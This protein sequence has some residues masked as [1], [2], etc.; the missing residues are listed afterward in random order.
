MSK[1][2]NEILD[3]LASY[4]DKVVT[5]FRKAHCHVMVRNINCNFDA[6]IDSIERCHELL[7]KY[8]DFFELVCI[9]NGIDD[10]ELR[11]QMRCRA[12]ERREEEVA[13]LD[14]LY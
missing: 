6:V 5:E 12:L 3:K 7:G 14:E 1:V 10:E 4:D 13:S 11:V 2:S 8:R 9:V